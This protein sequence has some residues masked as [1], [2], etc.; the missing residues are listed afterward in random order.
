M[1]NDGIFLANLQLLEHTENCEEK[2][3]EDQ[4]KWLDNFCKRKQIDKNNYKHDNFMPTNYDMSWDN[5]DNFITDRKKNIL[6][7]LISEL[8]IID[9]T[10]ENN[11]YFSKSV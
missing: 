10:S 8:N 5:F 6:E 2:R 1:R 9:P 7:R 4:K 3:M 11:H